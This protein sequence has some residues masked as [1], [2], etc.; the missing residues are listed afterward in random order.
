MPYMKVKRVFAFLVLLSVAGLAS[1]VVSAKPASAP[2]NSPSLP[3]PLCDSV[4]VPEGN[5]LAFRAYALGVQVYRWNGT[6]WAFVAPEATLFADA[7][8][9]GEVGTHYVG[10]TWESNSGSKVVAARVPGTGCTPDSTAIPWLLLQKVSTDG[11]GIFSRV[12][13]IQRVNTTGGIAP[14]VAGSV[15]G[16]VSEVPYT[17]EYFFYRAKD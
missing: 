4:R 2:S 13:Y 10:P 7:N 15:I 9:H 5:K 11:P 14:S 12:S 6:A 8:Y 3:A 16:E 17:A 1:A